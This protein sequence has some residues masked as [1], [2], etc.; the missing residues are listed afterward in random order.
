MNDPV[1]C[2]DCE[3]F[4][5]DDVCVTCE[6]AEELEED[7]NGDDVEDFVAHCEGY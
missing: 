1:T 5:V 6:Y 7:V 3:S 2:F 4:L